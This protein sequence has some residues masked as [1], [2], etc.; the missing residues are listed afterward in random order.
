M[1]RKI[2]SRST[3]ITAGP[4]EV[5]CRWVNNRKA[6]VTAKREAHNRIRCTVTLEDNDPDRLFPPQN[7]AI[8]RD[9]K[10]LMMLHHPELFACS[11]ESWVDA[12]F[13][14]GNF[15]LDISLPDSLAGQGWSLSG[16]LVGSEGDAVSCDEVIDENLLWDGALAWCGL[17]VNP[18]AGKVIGF[19]ATPSGTKDMLLP[20]GQSLIYPSDV[21]FTMHSPRYGVRAALDLMACYRG[22]APVEDFVDRAGAVDAETVR[23][24]LF[25]HVMTS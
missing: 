24:W 20:W 1:I 18:S 6:V 22:S 9:V 15:S 10:Y 2:F 3:R 11:V 7:Q 19:T 21:R 13:Y 12:M 25:E 14:T 5:T 16:M 23:E 17:A 4:Y 8:S